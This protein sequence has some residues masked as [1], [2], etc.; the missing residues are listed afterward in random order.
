[1]QSA[2]V[3]ALGKIQSIDIPIPQIESGELLI[4]TKLASICGSDLH[5]VN[6]GWN[7][8]EYPLPYG[9]PGHEGIGQVMDSNG[10]NGFDN[11]DLVLTVPNIWN[12][13]TFAEYQVLNPQY[14][15]RLP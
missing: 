1:M 9:Y 11:G 3:T 13:K 6:M 8:T 4:K 7:V 2:Q 10:V 12:S 5:I 15:L 14:L